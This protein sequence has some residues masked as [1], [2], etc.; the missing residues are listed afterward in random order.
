MRVLLRQGVDSAVEDNDGLTAA[1]LAEL[2]WQAECAAAI[3][4]RAT[5][6]SM[7]SVFM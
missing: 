7:E 3:K 1:Q 4:R 2:C 6:V 5:Q